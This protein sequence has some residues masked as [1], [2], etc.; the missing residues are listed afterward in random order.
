VKAVLIGAGQIARQ[1]LT[2]LEGIAGVEVAGIC[3]LAPSVAE[4][5]AERHRV[6]RWFTDHRTMLAEVRPAVVHVTT[7]PNSHFRLAMDALEAGAHVVLEKPATATFAELEQLARRAEQSHRALVEDYNYLF[8]RAPLEILRRIESGELGSVVHVEVSLCLDI[9]GP[10]GF[11]DPNAPH[12]ALGLRGG[13][14]ADFLPHL[15]SLAHLFV[16]RHRSVR[17]LWNKR[18]ATVLPSDEFRAVVEGERGTASLSFSGSSQP[19]AFWLRV[20]GTRMQASAN[21]FETRVT[22]DG[23]RPGPKP[24]RPFINGLL[25][26]RD[27]ARAAVGTLMRKFTGGPGSYEGLF[28]LLTR[29]YRAL[30]TGAELPVTL[31]QVMEV[32]RLV[33]A[34]KPLEEAPAAQPLRLATARD[35]GR[36]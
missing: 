30:H 5:A 7:P 24:L 31:D 3:D 1:H 12:P 9:L 32:N 18:S 13:A 14:I 26:G 10:S 34:L 21:L 16:G 11:A 33:E 2:C 23:L 22:F 15:A 8:N 28:E 6:P 17:T 20:Y 27:V 4:C 36:S 35:G 25:E 19:D 29:V